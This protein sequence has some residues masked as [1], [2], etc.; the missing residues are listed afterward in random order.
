MG[1]MAR[2]WQREVDTGKVGINGK[3]ATSRAIWVQDSVYASVGMGR[4]IDVALGQHTYTLADRYIRLLQL[5]TF[6]TG[7]RCGPVHAERSRPWVGGG[8]VTAH[9]SWQWREVDEASITDYIIL[10]F[11][12]VGGVKLREVG[13]A[14][15]NDRTRSRYR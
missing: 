3:L 1:T 14:V 10:E 8:R 4:R 12:M 13:D 2:S 5:P 6:I 15:G 11:S 9:L 7:Q